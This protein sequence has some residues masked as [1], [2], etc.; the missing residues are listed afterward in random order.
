V[1]AALRPIL[2]LLLAAALLGSPSAARGEEP[3]E[4]GPPRPPP[5]PHR[6]YDLAYEARLS[7]NERTARVSVRIGG[8]E[9]GLVHKVRFRIDPE[10]H[11][12]FKGDGVVEVEGATVT[13]RPPLRGGSLHYTFRIDHLRDVRSYDAHFAE[14]WA[15]FRGDD[16]VP[17]ARVVTEDAALA[18]ARLRLR[19]PDG[20]SAAAPWERLPDGRFVLDNPR[21]RFDRPTGWLLVGRLGILREKVAGSRV[22]IAAP[23]GQ[24][25][26]RQD[27]LA[28][29]RW[30]L[31]TLR[32]ILGELP[33]RLVVLGSGDPMWRGGLSGPGSVFVHA[34][35]P[36]VASDLTSPVLHEI[37]HATLGITS[38]DGGDWVVEGLAE[39]YS[40]ELLGRSKTLSKARYRKA[41]ALL[42]ARGAGVTALDVDAAV[43]PVAARAAAALHEL[44]L[45]LRRGSEERISLDDVV[46]RLA[47]E[48]GPVTTERFRRV[49]DEL[50]GR[51]LGAFFRSRVPL[52]KQPALP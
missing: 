38:A 32:K 35:R 28:L 13:W 31:P 34:D 2:S 49:V 11:R 42:G 4:L 37:I 9:T 27:T 45:E 8:P 20:W 10:R 50:A 33:P 26:R 39:L 44:D 17:P 22:A 25:V 15:L 30:T 23:V 19:L 51:S 1:S 52:K 3:A 46:R 14:N 6:L 40:L 47:A 7:P 18:R 21:R 29:L 5:A 16:L 12:D 43:G 41:L 36:L 48:R 24:R